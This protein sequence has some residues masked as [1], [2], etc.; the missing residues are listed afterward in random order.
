MLTNLFSN[1]IKTL[2]IEN[3]C[4]K[5]FKIGLLATLCNKII[6]KKL[7]HSTNMSVVAWHSGR[8]SVCDGQTFDLQL[9]S[10]HLCE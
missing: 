9:M 5:L 4:R 3:S 8:T 10:D 1:I 2:K 6:V 7:T